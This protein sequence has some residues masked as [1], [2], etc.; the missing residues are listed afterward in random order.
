MV[1]TFAFL[2]GF[3]INKDF[4]LNKIN[5]IENILHFSILQVFIIVLYNSG[6]K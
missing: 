6:D 1:F 5:P 2:I 3:T 4:I